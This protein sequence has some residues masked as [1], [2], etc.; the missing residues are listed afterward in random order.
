M[1]ID[2]KCPN[3]SI[4]YRVAES[5]LRRFKSSC[6]SRRC[7]ILSHL[8]GMKHGLTESREYR[9]WTNIKTRCLNTANERY[10]DYGGR[11]ITICEP[12]KNDFSQFLQDMGPCPAGMQIERSNNNEGYSPGNCKWTTPKEQNNNRRSN[13][14]ITANGETKTLS[15][16]A[17][18]IGIDY[19]KLSRA[20]KSGKTI[21]DLISAISG[22]LP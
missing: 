22:N 20:I 18:S 8:P 9:I 4:V 10:P 6:C 14:R 1:L 16:W 13:V 21:N 3:C 5:H 15:Q 2:R 17:E 19:K 7:N 12:W 11:G